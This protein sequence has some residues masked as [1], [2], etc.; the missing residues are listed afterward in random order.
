MRRWRCRLFHRAHFGHKCME[1][2]VIEQIV[3]RCYACRWCRR[4]WMVIT[5]VPRR[6]SPIWPRFGQ[7]ARGV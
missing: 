7:K 4:R 1:Q 6:G 5:A 2:V 3:V